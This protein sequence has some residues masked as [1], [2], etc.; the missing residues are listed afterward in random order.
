M[1]VAER[2]RALDELVAAYLVAHPGSRPSTIVVMDLM[3][4]SHAQLEIA[5]TSAAAAHVAKWGPTDC[6]ACNGL[7]CPICCP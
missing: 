6:G 1:T 2:H 3:V 4:W 7:G 5:Q